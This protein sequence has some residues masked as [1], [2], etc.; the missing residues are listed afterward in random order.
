[1]HTAKYC[2]KEISPT[3]YLISRTF[4]AWQE[5]GRK[6]LKEIIDA[7]LRNILAT[8]RP[9]PLPASVREQLDAIVEKYAAG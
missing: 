9:E 8:H 1:M 4:D 6:D 3:K 7:D 2:R 5:E